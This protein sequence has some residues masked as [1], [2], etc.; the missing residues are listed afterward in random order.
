MGFMMIIAH[1]SRWGVEDL[2]VWLDTA[3][4]LVRLAEEMCAGADR[5][6]PEHTV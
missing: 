2:S 3:D 6:V 4:N 1:W 5:K